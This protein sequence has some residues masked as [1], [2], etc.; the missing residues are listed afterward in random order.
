MLIN[1]RAKKFGAINKSFQIYMGMVSVHRQ[2][3]R[4]AHFDT[5]KRQFP[6]INV[7]RAT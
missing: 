3:T 7:P 1:H 5:L 4:T 2:T 6:L